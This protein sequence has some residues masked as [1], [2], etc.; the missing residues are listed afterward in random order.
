MLALAYPLEASM[1][2]FLV[3]GGVA[4]K[5]RDLGGDDTLPELSARIKEAVKER[6]IIDVRLAHDELLLVNGARLEC[7]LLWDDRNFT[8]PPSFFALSARDFDPS[9]GAAGPVHE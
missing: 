7:A 1:S 4:W 5:L 6:T 2:K 9:G 8:A 3:C